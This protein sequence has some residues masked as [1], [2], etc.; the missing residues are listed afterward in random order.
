MLRLDS[1]LHSGASTRLFK[2]ELK[3]ETCIFKEVRLIK[4][5]YISQ[6]EFQKEKE[7][8]LTLNSIYPAGFPKILG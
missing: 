3:E 1:L 2:A 8:I 5:K 4:T 6:K 7:V